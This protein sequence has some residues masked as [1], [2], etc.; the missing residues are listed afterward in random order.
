MLFMYRPYMNPDT[1]L[2]KANIIYD[3]DQL[4]NKVA[5]PSRVNAIIKIF[6]RPKLSAAAPQKKEHVMLPAIQKLI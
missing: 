5:I 1:N 4:A 6:F 2:M 3:G